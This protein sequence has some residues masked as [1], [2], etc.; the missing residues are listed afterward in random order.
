[1]IPYLVSQFEK[2]TLSNLVKESFGSDFPDVLTKRQI[3]YMYSYL[4]DLGAK[5]IVLEFDYL[6][7]DYLEDF[8]RYYV[9]RFNG[10]GS[11]CARLHFFS[12]VV[13]HGMIEGALTLPS[14]LDEKPRLQNAYLGFV[15]VKP[16]PKTFIGRTC[17]KTYESMVRTDGSK[18]LLSREYKVDLFGIGLTVKSIAF[19]EQDKVVSACAT[20]AI[21]SSL[22]AMAW[23][24]T[25]DIPACSE[26]TI[27]A[28]NHIDGSSNSFPSKELSN[29]QILRALDVEHLRNH[30]QPLNDISKDR[31]LQV[32]KY[33]VDSG[34]PL[35]LGAEVYAV[36]DQTRLQLLAGHAV[37]VLGYKLTSDQALYIH[38]DR[39]GP[40][41]RA[42]FVLM[43]DF[44]PGARESTNWALVLQEK[45]DEGNWLPPHEVL[46]PKSLVMPMHKKVRLPW[47][48][49]DATSSFIKSEYET[50][51]AGL[52]TAGKD[53]SALKG[54]IEYSLRLAEISSIRQG[55]IAYDFAKAGPL[56]DNDLATL[57]REKIRF[58]TKS[59]ARFHW[60]VDF[61][62]GGKEAFQVLFDATDIPQ[63]DAVAGIF[64]KDVKRSDAILQIF[65]QY[66]ASTDKITEPQTE[67][68]YVAFLKY[69]RDV[70]AS[71]LDYLNVTYGE[72]RAPKYLK[73]SELSGS[74]IAANSSKR[75]Y[76]LA[77]DKSL[78]DEFSELILDDEESF[79]IWA[80]AQDG[81]LLVGKEINEVG[82][83]GLTG[84]KPA[85]IAGELRRTS[86]GWMINSK[87]GRYSKDYSNA[88]DLLQNAVEKFNVVFYKSRGYVHPSFF[89]NDQSA[90]SLK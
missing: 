87:S 33:H 27:N 11:R 37:S 70:E 74:A 73:A 7:K 72:L 36:R 82:H 25:R 85:R 69:L 22:H 64:L 34:L 56:E 39:L 19:Q 6:D 16:L 3:G 62:F 31:F 45:D 26:I 88:N 42:K 20:T 76:F 32:V 80:I 40:F 17:L 86:K 61:T 15:V 13:T 51:L 35:I 78:E 29:K 84:F 24:S 55:I 54:Q 48:Y 41:A 47:S 23:R 89:V 8:S 60:V 49:A 44:H 38:D 43:E 30:Y 90:S 14:S 83:P 52:E 10:G 53:V 81:S 77:C 4:R 59:Y 58:L 68:F 5:S 21:W 9:K 46:V 2:S 1:M 71:Y 79:M 12:T 66:S 50:W 28:I 18:N 65:R 67:N 57:N 75:Q 63:G